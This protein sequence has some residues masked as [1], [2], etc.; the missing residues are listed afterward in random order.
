MTDKKLTEKEIVSFIGN[1]ISAAL[2]DESGDVAQLRKTNFDYYNGEGY[3]DERDGYSKVVTRECLETVEWAS[4]E[5][6][7][8]FVAS[9]R[10][11]S[12]DP[13]GPEDE[14]A[15]NQ[16]T[17]VTN[18]V[19]MKENDWYL[20]AYGIVKDALMYP[21]CYAK[22]WVDE[23]ED[24]EVNYHYGLSAPQVELLES[25]DAFEIEEADTRVINSE[26]GP[27]QVFDC[28]VRHTKTETK[29]TVQSVPAEEVLIDADHLSLDLDKADFV[30]HRR[31]RNFTD[32]VN[33]GYDAER[34]REIGSDDEGEW[35]DERSNRLFFSEESPDQ[36]GEDDE[37]M[38][39]FWV[40]E[41][42]VRLDADGDGLAERRF[43]LMIGDEVFEN[44]EYAYQPFACGSA[45]PMNHKHIGQSVL[46]LTKDIQ[47]I[48]SVLT[49]QL[50]DNT[51]R[52]NSNRKYIGESALVDGGLTM[53]QLLD[54]DNE[55]IQ[56]R[57]PHAIIPELTPSIINELL[58][59]IQHMED[60]G[61][62]RTGIDFNTKMDKDVLQNTTA[63]AFM[64]ALERSSKQVEAYT[65]SL[66]ETVFKQLVRK[67]HQ[68]L[69]EHTDQK[70]VVQIRGQWVDV[71]PREWKTRHNL[72]VN[73]GLGSGNKDQNINIAMQ[74]LSIQKEA[75]QG[76]LTDTGKIYNTLEKLVEA[77]GW[78]NTE[79]YFKNPSLEP[80]PPPQPDPMMQAVMQEQARKNKESEV[81]IATKM[82][83]MQTK[84]AEFEAKMENMNLDSQKKA[85]EAAKAW[86]EVGNAEMQPVIQGMAQQ[87]SD[88]EGEQRQQP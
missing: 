46:E 75:L 60:R 22:I 79:K 26:Q 34:L 21:N 61:I 16:E 5:I 53:D 71:D 81:N 82:Q 54:A 68:L 40:H 83:D 72:T 50:L 23:V 4:A 86:A 48:S 49:R 73:V 9:D 32:L 8:A 15:A 1:K 52:I 57:D 3:G 29:I 30:C 87:A 10:A 37:S 63:Q 20:T 80:P 66:A 42:Y 76:G 6:L 44:E 14:D 38:R 85:G 11:V 31:Q 77:V 58:P 2:N 17:D 62:K 78:K 67:T 36:E 33:E 84:L 39:Q 47:H 70:K 55:F 64:G 18:H 56:C 59:V 24:T 88:F 74:M 65:R 28:K 7:P 19:L 25:D 45:I 13:V 12:F 35:N 69:R 51:Y 41:C 43:I 27:I